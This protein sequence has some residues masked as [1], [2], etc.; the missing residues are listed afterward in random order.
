MLSDLMHKREH[1]SI[2]FPNSVRC[3]R[4]DPVKFCI[5]LLVLYTYTNL[6]DK[7]LIL[8]LFFSLIKNVL[9]RVYF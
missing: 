6:S 7:K 8:N 4:R 1:S 3:V 2:L 9:P 5:S